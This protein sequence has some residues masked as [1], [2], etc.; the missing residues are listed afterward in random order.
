[1]GTF[2]MKYQS[3]AELY[4]SL[5]QRN[6]QPDIFNYSIDVTSGWFVRQF[7]NEYNPIHVHLGSYLSCVGYLKLPDGIDEEWEEDYKDHHPANGHIQFVYGHA[8]NHTGSNCLMKPRV[9]DF[10]VFPAHLHHCV[11]PFKTKGERRSFSVNCTIS[12]TYKE[13]TKNFKNLAELQ[14]DLE[15]EK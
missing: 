2:L 12:A 15:K 13:E 3:H 8:A 1:M 5:G 7:E 14:K 4:T 11:Y 10:Y 9:G 6:I